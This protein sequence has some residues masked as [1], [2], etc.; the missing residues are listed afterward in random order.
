MT[1]QVAFV[2]ILLGLIILPFV[3]AGARVAPAW[4]RDCKGPASI[5]ACIGRRTMTLRQ[6]DSIEYFINRKTRA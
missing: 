4:A 2:G 3:L 6:I 5:Q 1:R